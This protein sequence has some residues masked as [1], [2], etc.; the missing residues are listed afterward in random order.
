MTYPDRIA[1]LGPPG[2]KNSPSAKLIFCVRRILLGNGFSPRDCGLFLGGSQIFAR[3]RGTKNNL[4]MTRAAK[5]CDPACPE[6]CIK[7]S[8]PT[9]TQSLPRPRP[10]PFG[11]F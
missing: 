3:P 2:E 9:P 6:G 5:T 8:V 4:E 7:N 1:F 11:V 10:W